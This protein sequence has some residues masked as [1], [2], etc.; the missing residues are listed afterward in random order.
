MFATPTAAELLAGSRGGPE[1]RRLRCLP[2]LRESI[3]TAPAG[4]GEAVA[5]GAVDADVQIAKAVAPPGSAKPS[6]PEPALGRGSS[7]AIQRRAIHRGTTRSAAAARPMGDHARGS[8]SRRCGWQSSTI[9][10]ICP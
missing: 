5:T 8:A 9:V 10:N 3:D 7:A 1:S 6:E 2:P 4:F